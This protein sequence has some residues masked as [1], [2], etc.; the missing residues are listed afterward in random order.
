[1]GL[2]PQN[3]ELVRCVWNSAKN[4]PIS[5]V[6]WQRQRGHTSGLRWNTVGSDPNSFGD[7]VGWRYE[8]WHVGTSGDTGIVSN[9]LGIEPMR[10][11]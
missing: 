1:M 5:A 8:D 9:I 2:F 6:H 7:F 4:M 11:T 3:R 10:S